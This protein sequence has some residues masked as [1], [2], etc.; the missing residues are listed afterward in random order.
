MNLGS[1]YSRIAF[2]ATAGG[3]DVVLSTGSAGKRCYLHSLVCTST[4]AAGLR[5]VSGAATRVVGRLAGLKL[6]SVRFGK[7]IETCPA[8]TRGGSLKLTTTGSA[9]LSGFAA[10]SHSTR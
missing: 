4:D 6:V 5:V 8:S 3:A 10:I 9:V 7:T 2:S 1:T